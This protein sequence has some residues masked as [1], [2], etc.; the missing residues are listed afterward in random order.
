M[1]NV[2]VRVVIF[3]KSDKFRK[4]KRIFVEFRVVYIKRHADNIII[5]NFAL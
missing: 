1:A 3:D 4:V 2:C 5:F